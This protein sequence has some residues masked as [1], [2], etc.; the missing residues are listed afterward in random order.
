MSE[1]AILVFN[2]VRTVII[3]LKCV[4]VIYKAWSSL[5]RYKLTYGGWNQY[6]I[7]FFIAMIAKIIAVIIH[8]FLHH[9]INL[10]F[11]IFI[12]NS[13]MIIAASYYMHKKILQALYNKKS[14]K[15]YG[16]SHS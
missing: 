13:A 2:I 8:E 1:K 4:F 7:W 15:G 9:S 14:S 5:A 16:C 12:G 11:F 10:F 6:E 3:M